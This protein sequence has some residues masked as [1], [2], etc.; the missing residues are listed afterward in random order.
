MSEAADQSV[1]KTILQQLGG[2]KFVMMTG[3]KHFTSYPDALTFQLP[4]NFATDGI[5]HVRIELGWQ[6]TYKITFT[7]ARRMKVTK[8]TTVEGV[9]NDSLQSVFTRHTGLDT[10]MG[11][12][13]R[14]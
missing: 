12:I 9:Y 10:T 6:D 14:S 2:H 7:T 1:A 5:N 4:Y 11:R 3:A 13:L 8:E